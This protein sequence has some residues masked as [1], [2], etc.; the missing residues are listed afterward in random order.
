[1]SGP[2]ETVEMDPSLFSERKSVEE[3]ID[4]I[5]L[6]ATDPPPQIETVHRS[7]TLRAA[8][9][10]TTHQ[11]LSRACGGCRQLQKKS[12]Q[13]FD[14][15]GLTGIRHDAS[16]LK[17]VL[18]AFERGLPHPAKSLALKTCTCRRATGGPWGDFYCARPVIIQFARRAVYTRC[19]S[20]LAQYNACCI[21]KPRPRRAMA[22]RRSSSCPSC[23]NFKSLSYPSRIGC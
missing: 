1:M 6:A 14:R 20:R 2:H 18:I 11:A 15:L 8:L 4:Q 12:L 22:F 13:Q 17:V 9:E 7:P 3:C 19:S 21:I 5:G 10:Q 23:N 16:L